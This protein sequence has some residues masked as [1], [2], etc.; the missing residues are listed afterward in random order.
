MRYYLIPVRMAVINKST[1]NKYWQGCGKKNP[2][3]LLVGMHIVATSM[4]NSVKVSQK[5]KNKIA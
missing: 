1:N 3:A 5:I 2:H 4:E